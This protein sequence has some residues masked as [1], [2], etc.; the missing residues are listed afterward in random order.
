MLEKMKAS[1]CSVEVLQYSAAKPTGS[2][3]GASQARIRRPTIGVIHN[4]C[5]GMRA[6]LLISQLSYKGLLH[7]VSTRLSCRSASRACRVAAPAKFPPIALSLPL[8]KFWCLFSPPLQIHC[9]LGFKQ[10]HTIVLQTSQNLLI[11][12]FVKITM[13]LILILACSYSLLPFSPQICY[14]S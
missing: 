1:A 7:W 4:S 10:P 8:S 3:F 5:R 6:S 14:G 13:I 12:L 2:P 9:K 11:I